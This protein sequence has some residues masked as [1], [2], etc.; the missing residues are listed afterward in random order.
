MY[1]RGELG[2]NDVQIILT[3]FREYDKEDAVF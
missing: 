1:T 3:G 2:E